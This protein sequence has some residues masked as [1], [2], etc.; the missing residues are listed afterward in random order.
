MVVV[1]GFGEPAGSS[2]L[3]VVAPQRADLVLTPNV[4]HGE[5]DVL[6]LDRLHVEADGR[7]RGDDFAKLQLVQNSR[8]P[9]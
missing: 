2:D 1:V 7:N 4:P 6:V 3:V 9:R 8:F 5:A